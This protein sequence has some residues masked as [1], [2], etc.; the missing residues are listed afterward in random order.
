IVLIAF[1]LSVVVL[2]YT[3]PR[4]ERRGIDPFSAPGVVPGLIGLILLCLALILFVRSVRRGGYRL[5][6]RG[7][8]A[9]DQPDRHGR[10]TRVL[11]TLGVSLVYAAGFLGRLNYSVATALYIFAFICL[12]EYRRGQGLWAQRRTCFFA[13]LQAVLA[14]LLITLVFQ[15]LFLVDLP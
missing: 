8:A 14:S 15:K 2:S 1:S 6:D 12:F 9:A 3:M 11:L 10:V 4:L 5:F 13:L 7:S